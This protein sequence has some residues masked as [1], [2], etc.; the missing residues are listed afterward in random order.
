[1]VNS[2]PPELVADSHD[3]YS[4]HD[5]PRDP[6]TLHALASHPEPSV[7][8]QIALHPD[9]PVE[10]LRQLAA[11][12][13]PWVRESTAFNPHTPADLLAAHLA[14]GNPALWFAL[15]H[16]P[17]LSEAQQLELVQLGDVPSQLAIANQTNATR[18]WQAILDSGKARE[19]DW[20][21]DLALALDPKTK[22]SKF[23][24]LLCENNM[25]LCVQK[26]AA[27]HSNCPERFWPLLM[28]YL[29]DQ[30]AQNTQY[31]LQLLENPTSL[32]SYGF[33]QWKI[34]KWLTSANAP[35]M[36]SRYLSQ[37]ADK[38]SNRLRALGAATASLADVQP[39]LLR[40]SVHHQKR[41]AVR[42]DLTLFMQWQLTRSPFEE[43]RDILARNLTCPAE[44]Q[45]QLLV[46]ED[47]GVRQTLLHL[48]PELAANQ[49]EEASLEERIQL[50]A[51]LERPELLAELAQESNPQIRVAVAS[52][53][54]TDEATRQILLKDSDPEVRARAMCHRAWD[55]DGAARIDWLTA[56]ADDESPVVRVKIAEMSKEQSLLLRFAADPSE[57]VQQ[58][59]AAKAEQIEV[60][61]QLRLSPFAS[62]QELW[63]TRIYSAL[64]YAAFYRHLPLE[65]RQSLV[66]RKLPDPTA[67]LPPPLD[68][69]WQWALAKEADPLILR[70]ALPHFSVTAALE[71]LMERWRREERVDLEV[72]ELAASH[73]RL[74]ANQLFWAQ[75][76]EESPRRS[77][78]N[79]ERL[80]D[81]TMV[82]LLTN[83]DLAARLELLDY[84]EQQCSSERKAPFNPFAKA[85]P[86]AGAEQH[87]SK[88]PADEIRRRV[89]AFCI[90]PRAIARLAEDPSLE[91]RRAMA[92][93]M[94][95]SAEQQPRRERLRISPAYKSAKATLA[96][97][98]DPLIQEI[99]NTRWDITHRS[100]AGKRQYEIEQILA[101]LPRLRNSAG[102]DK[103][104]HHESEA[105]RQAIINH[106]SCT[107]W[108]LIRLSHDERPAVQQAITAFR[109]QHQPPF[110]DALFTQLRCM[111]ANGINS[112]LSEW[113]QGGDN[114]AIQ[115]AARFSTDKATLDEFLCLEL[116]IALQL[117]N[118]H[119]LS[120]QQINRLA[121][122]EEEPLQLTI[123]SSQRL[124]RKMR[125]DDPDHLQALEH[126]PHL[127]VRLAL[128]AN[129]EM[130]TDRMRALYLDPCVEIQLIAI[131][132]GLSTE[133]LHELLDSPHAEVVIAAAQFIKDWRSFEPGAKRK[134]REHPDPEVQAWAK[135]SI[136]GRN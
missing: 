17:A 89:A 59:V 98:P 5:T 101:A 3:I 78:L 82:A 80:S 69:A 64:H 44:I 39:R 122:R 132:L 93:A 103:Y 37:H 109:S 75:Q 10:T 26:A 119:K 54:Y 21:A 107:L 33:E 68:E 100:E 83:A 112:R 126:S 121:R 13:V 67:I 22:A 16:N 15:A 73:T 120:A 62:I 111:D 45:Q 51:H 65:M 76:P 12:S 79:N 43:V 36:V 55:L 115:L 114:Q 53:S 77:L 117:L 28:C 127:S 104:I 94:T 135:K 61:R 23:S 85:D 96:Q 124:V 18:V 29:P 81:E 90:N 71:M 20:Y 118:N 74:V 125:N 116:P 136:R 49:L 8:Y 91:V 86:F 6:A 106:P 134:L 102:L 110:P 128:C 129:Q 130:P 30:I 19:C 84:L 52:N 57:A 105:V 4:W 11:D 63:L 70:A 40:L 97:D 9:T 87:L 27:L 88:D 58:V 32:K 31:A 35:G 131:R 2:L 38:E 123:A 113:A 60:L 46:D 7:R 99:I 41:I 34:D 14:S 50:V 92:E 66:A 133:P 1:M 72:C 25:P 48:R 56:C 95:E 24:R 47:E 42:A 108:Q